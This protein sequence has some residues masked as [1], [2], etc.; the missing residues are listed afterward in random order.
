MRLRQ[1]RRRSCRQTSAET[2]KETGRQAGRQVRRQGNSGKK[3][4][5]CAGNQ[6]GRHVRRQVGR[7]GRSDSGKPTR[8]T[9]TQSLRSK[10]PCTIF[11]N[12]ESTFNVMG[13]I[14]ATSS[15]YRVD[16]PMVRPRSPWPQHPPANSALSSRR[17]P[18]CCSG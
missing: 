2:S 16:L 12:R 9:G 13:K 17:P 18:T 5:D 10:N 3:H 7:Q 4:G 6:L 14:K 15:S 8:N 1:T 11:A